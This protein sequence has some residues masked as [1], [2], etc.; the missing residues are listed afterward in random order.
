MTIEEELQAPR[1][2]RPYQR[3]E[4]DDDFDRQLADASAKIQERSNPYRRV[5]LDLTDEDK[6][7]G[8]WAKMNDIPKEGWTP[9]TEREIG[10]MQATLLDPI[11]RARDAYQG[12]RR[13]P[14]ARG[15][16]LRKSGQDWLR[17]NPETGELEPAYKAEP[18]PDNA[19]RNYQVGR[20][21]DKQRALE[22]L[23]S[24]ELAMREARRT[25]ADIQT[26]LAQLET[27]AGNLFSGAANLPSKPQPAPVAPRPALMA[28][29]AKDSP[30]IGVDEWA[31]N[32]DAQRRKELG[33]PDA[34]VNTGPVKPG[35]RGSFDELD[36]PEAPSLNAP[37]SGLRPPPRT[38]QLGEMDALGFRSDPDI[39]GKLGNA[40]SLGTPTTVGAQ[41]EAAKPS[42]A[43]ERPGAPAQPLQAGQYLKR[44]DGK[45]RVKNAKGI[46]GWATA[47]PNNLPAGW[48]LSD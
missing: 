32:F 38:F 5:H 11:I 27:D 16:S 34:R 45:I 6:A 41:A 18:K 13:T 37:S 33:L 1:R 40:P 30:L 7:K 31:N 12:V 21:T 3:T 25:K 2:R 8:Y 9:P 44:K 14:P 29:G 22:R 43:S 20:I 23:M 24:D 26:E 39:L 4:I 42:P 15:G 47:D 46:K 48:S 17:E 19:F 36:E 28:I 35:E 10:L